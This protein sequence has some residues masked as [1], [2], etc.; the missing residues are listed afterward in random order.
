MRI[1]PGVRPI[2]A[3]RTSGLGFGPGRATKPMRGQRA[4]PAIAAN[5]PRRVTRQDNILC[6]SLLRTLVLTR[7]LARDLV[8]TQIFQSRTTQGIYLTQPQICVSSRNACIQSAPA[9]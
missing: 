4:S 1:R 6:A 9:K 3:M 7:V 5:L 2:L 8:L